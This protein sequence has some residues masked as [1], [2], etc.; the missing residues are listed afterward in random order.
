MK[1]AHA[2]GGLQV[3]RS[4]HHLA[5]YG[6]PVEVDILFRQIMYTAV[7]QDVG[8]ASFSLVRVSCKGFDLDAP[9]DVVFTPQ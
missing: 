5:P 8:E 3:T 2:V 6:E 4:L 7:V 1:A 9:G